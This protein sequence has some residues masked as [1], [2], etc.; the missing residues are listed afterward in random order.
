MNAQS[1]ATHMPQE[2]RLTNNI[3]STE[4]VT[5]LSIG[6]GGVGYFFLCKTTIKT[7]VKAPINTKFGVNDIIIASYV[8]IFPPPFIGRWS[9]ALCS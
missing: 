7:T 8:V 1:V 4:K 5:I 2:E 6:R 3:I 9:T